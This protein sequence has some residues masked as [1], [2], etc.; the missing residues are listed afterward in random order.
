MA[1]SDNPIA[2]A[3][4]TRPKYVASTTLTEP[5]WADTTVLSGDVAAA[6]GELKA[7]PGVKR[8]ADPLQQ[9][10]RGNAPTGLQAG[11]GRLSHARTDGESGPG[12]GQGHAALADFLLGLAG[13]PPPD[14]LP[15]RP[16]ADRD[17]TQVPVPRSVQVDPVLAEPMAPDFRLGHGKSVTL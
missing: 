16:V 2:A 6:V 3:L 14:R 4:N 13:D 1:D 15:V 12:Q 9:G 17:R 7:K 8:C 11:Q 10:D 5:R